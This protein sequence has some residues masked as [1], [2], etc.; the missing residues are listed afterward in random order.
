LEENTSIPNYEI[1]PNS[2]LCNI[3]HPGAMRC[4]QVN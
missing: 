4:E 1:I 3:P 2:V